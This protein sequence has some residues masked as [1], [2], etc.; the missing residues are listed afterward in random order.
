MIYYKF[1]SFKFRNFTTR[2]NITNF[3][4]EIVA[5]FVFLTINENAQYYGIK[6][7]VF[8]YFHKEGAINVF[9]RITAFI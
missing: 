5:V 9:Y 2:V 4:I 7:E 8:N 6:R 3:P 1:S